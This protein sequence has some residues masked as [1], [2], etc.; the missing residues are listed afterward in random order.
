MKM[1]RSLLLGTAAGMLAMSMV[2]ATPLANEA[3]SAECAKVSGYHTAFVVVL[4]IKGDDAR[5]AQ[6]KHV[7]GT[8]VASVPGSGTGGDK[9]V[10]GS[11]LIFD[12]LAQKLKSSAAY[13]GSP[14]RGFHHVLGK[15]P[16]SATKMIA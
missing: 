5:F 7:I 6:A 8:R 9:M 11:D 16:M 3:Q 10:D 12:K 4:P 1:V 13:R 15:I 14:A 2:H